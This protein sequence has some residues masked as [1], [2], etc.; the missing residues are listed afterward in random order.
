M[1][2]SRRILLRWSIVSSMS[3][4][5]GGY[6]RDHHSGS[7]EPLYIVYLRNSFLLFSSMMFTLSFSCW[8]RGL[9]SLQLAVFQGPTNKTTCFGQNTYLSNRC[10]KRVTFLYSHLVSSKI[11]RHQRRL[12]FIAIKVSLVRPLFIAAFT[13]TTH[14][15]ARHIGAR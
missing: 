15:P 6:P 11:S 2:I 8:N 4:S 5:Q 14:A 9:L 1:V 13:K 7:Q 3:Q 12:I 10:Q